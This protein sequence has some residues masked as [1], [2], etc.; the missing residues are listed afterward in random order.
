MGA[1]L[2]V[3][4]AEAVL[5]LEPEIQALILSLIHHIK[6]RKPK[7]PEQIAAA[8]MEWQNLQPEPPILGKGD[9]D[10]NAQSK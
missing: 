5:Q 4:I 3:S 8:T 10:Y 2:G 1:L 9:A 7:T 6:H